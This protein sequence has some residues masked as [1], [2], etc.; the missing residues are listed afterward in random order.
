MRAPLIGITSLRDQNPEGYYR[1]C[2]SEAYSTALIQTG[3]MPIL[4]PS[5]IAKCRPLELISRL[6]GILFSGGGDIGPSRYK[7]HSNPALEGVDLDRDDLEIQILNASIQIEIP[8]LGICRGLQLINVALGGTLYQDL[9]DERLGSIRHQY[10]PGWPRDHR[11]H[12]VEIVPGSSLENIF[13]TRRLEVNSLHHQGIKDI[14][15]RL[16]ASAFASDGL[17]EAIELSA[18][19]F[20]IAVQWHPECLLN[21]AGTRRLFQSFVAASQRYADQKAG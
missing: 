12:S 4:I 9:L 13:Q 7:N 18:Y 10:Y 17:V 5:G 6:D 16:Q 19:P 3:G 11:A 2:M 21:E 15:P 20:G 1:T 8:F 14:A